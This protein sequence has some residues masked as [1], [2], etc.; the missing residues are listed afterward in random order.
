MNLFKRL[1]SPFAAQTLTQADIGTYWISKDDALD[2]FNDSLRKIL[3]ISD[4]HVLICYSRKSDLTEGGNK[5]SMKFSS[6]FYLFTRY[7]PEKTAGSLIK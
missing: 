3:A 4:G 5:F 1:F 7:R 6:F 2:P